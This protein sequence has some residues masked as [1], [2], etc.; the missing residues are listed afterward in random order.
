MTRKN[1]MLLRLTCTRCR[2]GPMLLAP[3]QAAVGARRARSPSVSSVFVCPAFPARCAR[4]PATRS[5][6]LL[7]P[8]STPLLFLAPDAAASSSQRTP[9]RHPPL[10]M[11][12]SSA[13]G[14]EATALLFRHHAP[15][16]IAGRRLLALPRR[17]RR[18]NLRWAALACDC[19]C[20]PVAFGALVFWKLLVMCSGY[21]L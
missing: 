19:A 5:N 20:V 10:H 9:P 18:R 12:C 4:E 21:C 15:S 2:R 14:A 6:P 13:A 16:P 8:H 7:P 11:A 1:P 3:C 17:T